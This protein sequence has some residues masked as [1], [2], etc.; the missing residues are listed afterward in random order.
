[1]ETREASGYSIYLLVHTLV[2]RSNTSVYSIA[3]LWCLEANILVVTSDFELKKIMES[4]S[5][6]NQNPWCSKFG[7]T[8]V[9]VFSA[10]LL[11]YYST[12]VCSIITLLK[13]AFSH[14]KR[15]RNENKSWCL[16]CVMAK[17][18]NHP[19]GDRG[20]KSAMTCNDAKC[21]CQR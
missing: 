15:K 9:H 18:D 7:T 1:M 4:S 21:Q 19:W 2:C 20:Y 12:A 16:L 14:H 6:L 11:C 10:H 13:H 8:V 3:C 5:L 17:F